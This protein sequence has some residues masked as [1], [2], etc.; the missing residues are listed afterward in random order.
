[1]KAIDLIRA[2][3]QQSE[4]GTAAL[5]T[6]MRDDALTPATPGGK[7]GDGN[8]TLWPWATWRTSTGQ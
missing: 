6:D 3:M 1:M 8:H 5:V 4:Q 2:A 7:G